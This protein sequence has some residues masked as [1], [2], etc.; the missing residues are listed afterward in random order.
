MIALKTPTIDAHTKIHKNTHEKK[1][2][3]TSF[4][5]H[6]RI[7]KLCNALFGAGEESRTLDLYLGKVSLYQLSYSRMEYSFKRT[8][9]AHQRRTQ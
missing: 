3:E 6:H 5:M 4:F 9:R 8:F 1:E 7:K 2:A